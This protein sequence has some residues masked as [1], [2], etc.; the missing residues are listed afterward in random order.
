LTSL[1]FAQ[2]SPRLH[3]RQIKGISLALFHKKRMIN[4]NQKDILAEINIPLVRME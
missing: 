1:L 4:V 2:L 3:K